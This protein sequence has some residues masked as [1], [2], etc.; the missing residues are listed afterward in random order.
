MKI[1]HYCAGL[2]VTAGLL[3]VATPSQAYLTTGQTATTYSSTTALYTIT[4]RFGF[5]NREAYLPIATTRDLQFG[6]TSDD[7]GYTLLTRS[8]SSTSVGK[9]TALVLS[10][11]TIKNGR[12]YLPAGKS[13]TFTLVAALTLP[14]GMAASD[15]ALRVS[16]LPFVMID[17][18]KTYRAQLN[19]SELQ[20]Y[21]TPRAKISIKTT[22]IKS[23]VTV[24]GVTYSL[25]SKNGQ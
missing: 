25:S 8:G 20:Y 15:Y 1:H 23:P 2:V 3:G 16:S 12:Y 7:L 19:P 11:A 24:T 9:L 21:T 4:Y 5:L 22:T 17:D 13:G 6:T 14:N 18:K 10:N